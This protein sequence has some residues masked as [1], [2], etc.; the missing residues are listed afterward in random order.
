MH[1]CKD[2][3]IISFISLRQFV[4]VRPR[5]Y[6]NASRATVTPKFHH[7]YLATVLWFDACHVRHSA[8]QILRKTSQGSKPP[9][10]Q[11]LKFTKGKTEIKPPEVPS[12][13]VPQIKAVGIFHSFALKRAATRRPSPKGLRQQRL[14]LNNTW[15]KI[16]LTTLS[17]CCSYNTIFL[18]FWY[19]CVT[20]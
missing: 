10:F 8:C 9:A 13:H 5:M 12:S 19:F 3:I 1:S 16:N 6:V 2:L 17:A 15:Y 20:S 14:L 4:R 18:L 11:K 7:L